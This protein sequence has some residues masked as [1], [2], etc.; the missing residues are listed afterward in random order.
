MGKIQMTE[1]LQSIII[2]VQSYRR[3]RYADLF[4]RGKLGALRSYQAEGETY[5]YFV[6]LEPKRAGLDMTKNCFEAV[7]NYPTTETINTEADDLP[8]K[9]SFGW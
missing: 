3:W 6:S 4:A 2:A 7:L 5:N 1:A 8:K 9:F